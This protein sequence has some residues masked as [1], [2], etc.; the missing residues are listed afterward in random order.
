MLG[1]VSAAK[2]QMLSPLVAAPVI[3]MMKRKISVLTSMMVHCSTTIA[4]YVGVS[5]LGSPSLPSWKMKTLSTDLGII[6]AEN[7]EVKIQP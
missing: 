1:T 5:A 7:R 2:T 6:S 4:S 3:L